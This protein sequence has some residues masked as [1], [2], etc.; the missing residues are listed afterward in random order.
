MD[1]RGHRRV[2]RVRLDRVQ[3]LV[4]LRGDVVRRSVDSIIGVPRRRTTVR[5][6]LL[7]APSLTARDQRGDFNA[8]GPGGMQSVAWL[9]GI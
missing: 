6:G 9:A 5:S 4:E 8:L 3:P 2:A 1:A 7:E